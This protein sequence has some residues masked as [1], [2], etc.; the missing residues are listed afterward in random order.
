MLRCLAF[1]TALVVGAPYVVAQKL[2]IHVTVATQVVKDKSHARTLHS[3]LERSL[4]ARPR[5]LPDGHTI[6]AS[7]VQLDTAPVSGGDVE[8]RVEVR[9]A[10]ADERG[11]ILSVTSTKTT[12]RGPAKDRALVQRDAIEEAARQLAKRLTTSAKPTS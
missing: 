7:L 5:S 10:I 4:G 6:D 12:A 2:A 11:R 9:A 8:V 1:A 3:A